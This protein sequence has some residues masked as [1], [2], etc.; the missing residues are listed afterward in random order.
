MR[1][2]WRDLEALESLVAHVAAQ[3]VVVG[4]PARPRRHLVLARD[5]LPSRWHR[6]G[7]RR[8][9]RDDRPGGRRAGGSRRRP[10]AHR[11]RA[12]RRGSPDGA[13]VAPGT[14]STVRRS[15]APTSACSAG[16]RGAAPEQEQGESPSF[17]S[18]LATLLSSRPEDH[19]R[20]HLQGG[21]MATHTEPVGRLTCARR[22][23]SASVRPMERRSSSTI[24]RRARGRPTTSSRCWRRSRGSNRANR[25][26][27]TCSTRP[28]STTRSSRSGAGAGGPRGSGRCARCSSRGRQRT[29]SDPSTRRS[30]STTTRARPATP[31]SAGCRRSST[32][33][34]QVLEDNGVRVNY[35]EPPVPAI[36]AYGYIKN[37]VTLAGGGLVVH[38]GAILHR[39]G[40]GSWQKGREV[41]WEKV[42]AALQVPDLPDDPR[43]RRLRARSRPLARLQD[44]RLQRVRRRERGGAPTARVRPLEPR[45]RADRLPQPR[46][47]RHDRERQHRHI[48]HGHGHADRRRRGRCCSPR[49]SSTTASSAS[50]SGATTRSSRC[51]S[52]STGTSPSTAS[53][54]RPAR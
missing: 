31:T 50:S 52:R 37:L 10:D 46:L 48:P 12:G 34:T 39:Y 6:G 16:D 33:T 1:Q 13:A 27:T 29:R 21:M 38:G 23:H 42:L 2:Y 30:G 41:I 7:L 5:L 32:S 51:R 44:V 4:V 36:G 45:H 11:T 8:H 54:S 18:L 3:G 14:A 19:G 49:T 40:L 15:R 22:S 35:I 9:G 17:L 53:R 20:A 47:V 43:Q 28:T 26:A 25:C 24:P